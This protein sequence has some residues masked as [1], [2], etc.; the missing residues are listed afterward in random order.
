MKK[1]LRTYKPRLLGDQLLAP[2]ELARIHKE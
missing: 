1:K 2:A